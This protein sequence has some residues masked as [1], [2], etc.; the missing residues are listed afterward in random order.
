MSLV[1]AAEAPDGS[2]VSCGEG[3]PEVVWL[4][5][6]SCCRDAQQELVVCH[7]T[8]GDIIYVLD[9]Q[10][11]GMSDADELCENA[12][13]FTVVLTI[14]PS[15]CAL[16]A[17][18]APSASWAD[19]D[20][21][22]LQ[23][24]SIYSSSICKPAVPALEIVT[25]PLQLIDPLH[26]RCERQLLPAAELIC[27][28]LCNSHVNQTITIREVLLQPPPC[29]SVLWADG[30]SG[31]SSVLPADI[32]LA[33]QHETHLLASLS[34]NDDARCQSGACCH[35]A[36]DWSLLVVWDTEV[37]AKRVLNKSRL[38]MMK[39]HAEPAA[40]VLRLSVGA[41][42][43]VV[44][45]VATVECT[46]INA[47]SVTRN[48]ELRSAGHTASAEDSRDSRGA[49][50]LLLLEQQLSIGRL[51]AGQVWLF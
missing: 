37:C 48:L 36:D 1:P 43:I 25:A 17:S 46:V 31:L 8:N 42:D 13:D 9:V 21:H 16:D 34:H 22:R 29:M 24:S 18:V 10:L 49:E 12:L 50:A 26:V 3:S 45:V 23:L 38:P 27:V 19:V 40:V 14:T 5:I 28:K 4:D 11:G 35:T 7:L 32:C 44:G 41:Q 51:P 15:T 2:S 6:E 39:P 20:R 33:A 30:V 47:G